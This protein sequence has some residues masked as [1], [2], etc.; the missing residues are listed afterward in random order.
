MVGLKIYSASINSA[1]CTE[2][3]E[4]P[5]TKNVVQ[6]LFTVVGPMCHWNM[7]VRDRHGNVGVPRKRIKWVTHSPELARTLDARCSNDLANGPFHVHLHL[8]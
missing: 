3:G 4:E 5:V 2:F 7:E 8:R 1:I 6:A